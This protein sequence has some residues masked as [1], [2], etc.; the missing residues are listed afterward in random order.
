[1]PELMTEEEL[2][3]YLRVSLA[4]VRRWRYEQTGPPV[5]WAGRRPR[6]RKAEVDAWLQREQEES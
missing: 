5:E 4:T 6:Y 3:E 2:A 1:M